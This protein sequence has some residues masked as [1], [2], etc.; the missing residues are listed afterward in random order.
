MTST[1]RFG[2]KY[3]GELMATSATE[4]ARMIVDAYNKWGGRH[5][6]EESEQQNFVALLLL[7]FEDESNPVRGERGC[8]FSEILDKYRVARQS[9]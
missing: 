8:L 3:P 6:N 7:L 1:V 5:W 2:A 4:A 9:F